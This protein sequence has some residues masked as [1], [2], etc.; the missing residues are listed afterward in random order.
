MVLH[1]LLTCLP[2]GKNDPKSGIPIPIGFPIPL[3]YGSSI[4]EA[5]G[6]RRVHFGESLGLFQDIPGYSRICFKRMAPSPSWYEYKRPETF[7][8]AARE[9]YQRLGLV[10]T[11]LKP[12]RKL[13]C[14][15]RDEWMIE[16]EGREGVGRGCSKKPQ[17]TK[18]EFEMI[19]PAISR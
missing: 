15:I 6:N 17:D 14:F 2:V 7:F 5:Y 8:Q 4:W 1:F 12:H 11:L 9:A 18:S 10:P 19:F 16:W 3:L 13:G